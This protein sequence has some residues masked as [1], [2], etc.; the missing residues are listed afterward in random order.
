MSFTISAGFIVF[1]KR[2]VCVGSL[3]PGAGLCAFSGGAGCHEMLCAL[4]LPA[5]QRVFGFSYSLV[6]LWPLWEIREM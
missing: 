6:Y 3:C 5:V 4:Q 2:N 1:K